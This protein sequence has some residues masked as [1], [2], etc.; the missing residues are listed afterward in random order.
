MILNLIGFVASVVIIAAQFN[1]W[2]IVDAFLFLLGVASGIQPITFGLACEQNSPDVHGAAMGFNNM[3]VIAG[4][5]LVQPL[6]GWLLDLF[7]D[8]TMFDG[9]PVYQVAQYKYVFLI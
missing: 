6:V 8:H 3:A 9:A 4:G 2:F 7:W 5:V 1:N